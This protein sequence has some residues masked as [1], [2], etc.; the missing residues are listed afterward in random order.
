MVGS[1][2]FSR[3]ASNL[4]GL[5][6]TPPKEWS[7]IARTTS[8]PFQNQPHS[9]ICA[10]RAQVDCGKMAQLRG[11]ILRN[12]EVT[13][14]DLS[15]KPVR[16]ELRSQGWTR[17]RSPRRSLGD[18]YF[19]IRSGGSTIGKAGVDYFLDEEGV[20]EPDT[21]SS[22]LVLRI[23]ARDPVAL[24][25]SVMSAPV[26]PGDAQLE[27]A[28]QVIRDNY[29]ADIEAAE[30]RMQQRGH[31]A[32]DA[33]VSS[34][35]NPRPALPPVARGSGTQSAR[36]PVRVSLESSLKPTTPVRSG[37]RSSPELI[38]IPSHVGHDGAS[39]AEAAPS[40]HTSN[41]AIVPEVDDPSD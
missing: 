8:P 29:A 2:D 35:A 16:R 9:R 36:R 28:A 33:P 41:A 5:C 22:H 34:S 39:D 11:K 7:A 19:Y 40:S 31:A 17:K 18:R 15:F 25:A 23:R 27:A 1:N 10:R 38:A 37:R 30:A 26:A 4:R 21:D 3:L 24:A 13:A 6:D 14:C 32:V 20:L 12:S